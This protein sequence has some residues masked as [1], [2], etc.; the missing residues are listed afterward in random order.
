MRGCERADWANINGVQRIIVF[1]PFARMGGENGVTAAIGKTEHVILRNF[2]T[3]T[4]ATRAENAAFVIERDARPDLHA[5]RLFD[6]VFQK[7]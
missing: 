6:F 3:K 4:N 1:Q 5:F 7:T 2:L